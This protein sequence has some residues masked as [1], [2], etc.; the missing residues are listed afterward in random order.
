MKEE[1]GDYGGRGSTTPLTE[2]IRGGGRL[3]EG[4]VEWRVGL[5]TVLGKGAEH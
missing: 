1:E 3:K 2:Y 5:G 4:Q